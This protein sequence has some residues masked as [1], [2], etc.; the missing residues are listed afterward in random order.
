MFK[1]RVTERK[2]NCLSV[3]GIFQWILAFSC[4][5]LSFSCWSEY[6]NSTSLYST[7]YK[8]KMCLILGVFTVSWKC[9]VLMGHFF[10]LTNPK[11]FKE[12]ETFLIRK[13][14]KKNKTFHYSAMSCYTA[15]KLLPL[16]VLFLSVTL[17]HQISIRHWVLHSISTDKLVLGFFS[18]YKACFQCG[19][20]EQTMPDII[21]AWYVYSAI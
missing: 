12:W 14:Y 8:T 16:L 6:W 17:V 3:T 4:P 5:C 15:K 2:V 11:I 7:E 19:F 9:E 10:F 13:C 20:Y 1:C 18:D 21:I